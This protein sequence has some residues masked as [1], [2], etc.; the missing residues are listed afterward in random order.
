MTES[1]AQ[2]PG[3]ERRTVHVAVVESLR[4]ALQNVA[5]CELHL[6]SIQLVQE[7]EVPVI[8]LAMLPWHTSPVVQL[9]PPV[10]LPHAKANVRTAGA[11]TTAVI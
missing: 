4:Q 7:A 9:P 8:V 1:V 6:L 5:S 10:L 11:R 2:H 3:I